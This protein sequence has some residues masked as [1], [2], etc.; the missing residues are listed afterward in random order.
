MALWYSITFVETDTTV[1]NQEMHGPFETTDSLETAISASAEEA[2]ADV[3]A[4]PTRFELCTDDVPELV[5][6]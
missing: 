3:I 4:I 1:V 2:G 5:D 6:N